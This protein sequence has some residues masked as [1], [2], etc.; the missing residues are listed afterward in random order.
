[1]I[2]LSL[3]CVLPALVTAGCVHSTDSE[4]RPVCVTLRHHDGARHEVC[5]Y[6]GRVELRI[7]ESGKTKISSRQIQQSLTAALP[8]LEARKKAATTDM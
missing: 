8:E 6:G 7:L 4:S 3:A 5:D 1:M 2:K